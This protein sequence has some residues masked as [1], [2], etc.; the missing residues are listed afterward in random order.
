[1]LA[2]DAARLPCDK[3]TPLGRPVVPLVCRNSATSSGRA[4]SYK[5]PL[6]VIEMSRKTLLNQ[7]IGHPAFC[8]MFFSKQVALSVQKN[9]SLEQEGSFREEGGQVSVSSTPLMPKVPMPGKSDDKAH[10]P[11]ESMVATK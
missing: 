4:G 5:T 11:P 7:H 8:G 3:G 1:M 6:R 9:G 2:R 10:G